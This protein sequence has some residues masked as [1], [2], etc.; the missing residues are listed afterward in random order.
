MCRCLGLRFAAL[1]AG[2]GT[3]SPAYGGRTPLPTTGEVGEGRSRHC[4]CRT[5]SSH[6]RSRA[7]LDHAAIARPGTG[8]SRG[9]V[10]G[11]RLIGFA[12]PPRSQACLR[13]SG[14]AQVPRPA[15][16]GCVWPSG[17]A[18]RGRQSAGLD[19]ACGAPVSDCPSAESRHYVRTSTPTSDSPAA[20]ANGRYGR[21]ARQ[22]HQT[23]LE[24]RVGA[25]QGDWRR[26]ERESDHSL[27]WPS[28]AAS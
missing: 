13:A 16:R 8:A 26:S 2:G 3:R 17:C 11:S 27:S 9:A 24:H 5:R 22:L 25:R 18:A 12:D 15:A 4:L 6:L 10:H 1:R 7:S 28:A 21:H 23:D 20:R 14:A 19:A